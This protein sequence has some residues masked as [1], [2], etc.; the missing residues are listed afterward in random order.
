MIG[1]VLLAVGTLGTAWGLRLSSGP[2]PGS[3]GGAVLAPLS[4][5]LALAGTVRLFVPGFFS[6][7]P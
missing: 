2:R 7:T 5:L 3:L 4:L 6:G 1:A